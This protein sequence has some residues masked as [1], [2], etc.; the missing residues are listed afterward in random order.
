MLGRV[1]VEWYVVLAK[2][3]AD[4]LSLLMSADVSACSVAAKQIG[5]GVLLRGA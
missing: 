2:V 3:A 1:L 4:T 5:H